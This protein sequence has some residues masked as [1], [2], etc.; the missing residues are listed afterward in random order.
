MYIQDEDLKKIEH[1]LR[2]NLKMAMYKNEEV[3][4]DALKIV[5]RVTTDES[6]EEKAHKQIDSFLQTNPFLEEQILSREYSIDQRIHS[7]F[8]II[9]SVKV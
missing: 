3:L 9:T 6:P 7:V 8:G 2:D 1:A 5:E 4:Y